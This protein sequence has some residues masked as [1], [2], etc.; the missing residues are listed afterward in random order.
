MAVKCVCCGNKIG[1]FG[2]VGLVEDFDNPVC[3]KCYEKFSAK[4]DAFM[5]SENIQELYSR[6]DDLIEVLNQCGFIEDG[7]RYI[8]SYVN[9]KIEEI[10][11]NWANVLFLELDFFHNLAQV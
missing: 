9:S 2:E 3:D 5:K 1:L 7:K 6:Q 11:I 10:S 4:L 8:L